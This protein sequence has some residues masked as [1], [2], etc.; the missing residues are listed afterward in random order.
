[1]EEPYLEL[2][3]RPETGTPLKNAL[4]SERQINLSCQ[5][6]KILHDYIAHR[7]PKTTDKHGREP[8][9]TTRRGRIGLQALAR[10]VTSATRPCV[11][12]D[13]CPHDRD[14]DQCPASSNRSKSSKCPS[15]VSGHPVRRGSITHGHL[16]Q[17]VPKEVISDRT[18]VSVDMLDKHYDR[19][20]E[21]TKR[22]L[23]R[24]HLPGGDSE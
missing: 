23:R 11:Y 8:L 12:G 16:D 6:A 5:I 4:D 17:D 15:S 19:Q 2:V 18:D 22:Q 21:T 9:F 3:H 10:T 20:D 24:S 1:V 13:G 7:R 14:I